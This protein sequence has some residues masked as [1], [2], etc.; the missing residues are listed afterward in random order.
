MHYKGYKFAHNTMEAV[1][2]SSY[3]IRVNKY[4]EET[5]NVLYSA[6]KILLVIVKRIRLATKFLEL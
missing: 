4:L 3:E 2:A 6:L 1:L 5:V